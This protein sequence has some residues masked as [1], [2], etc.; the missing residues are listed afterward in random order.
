M[1]PM[2]LSPM[3][4]NTYSNTLVYM[5]QQCDMVKTLESIRRQLKMKDQES[6]DIDDL[7][8]KL[9]TFLEDKRYVQ[10]KF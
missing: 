8:W 4:L 5:G 3:G 1:G 9:R 7:T 2:G 10:F 6:I